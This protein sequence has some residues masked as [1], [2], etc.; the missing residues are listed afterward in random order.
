MESFDGSVL[1]G[2]AGWDPSSLVSFLV[3]VLSQCQSTFGRS[4]WGQ[5]DGPPMLGY[6]SE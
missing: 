1:H 2:G 5:R 6:A 3:P 4:G